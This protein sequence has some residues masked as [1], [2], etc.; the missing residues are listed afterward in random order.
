MPERSWMA[1]AHSHL[2]A[3][4]KE[5]WE[6]L[7]RIGQETTDSPGI[8]RAAW[9][10]NEETAADGVRLCPPARPSGPERRLRQRPVPAARRRSGDTLHHD[11]LAPRFGA[12]R[13][14]LRRP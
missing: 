11:R 7:E 9:S 6:L 3:F 4:I 2:D 5:V 10:R 1:D 13:R 12:A 14:Q 8:T